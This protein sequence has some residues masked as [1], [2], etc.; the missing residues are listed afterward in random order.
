MPTSDILLYFGR[1]LLLALDLEAVLYGVGYIPII[2]Q[3]KASLVS[4]YKYIKYVALLN[5]KDIII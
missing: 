3:Y 4:H 5:M 2:Y 1:V